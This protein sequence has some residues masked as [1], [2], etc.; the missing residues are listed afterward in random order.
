MITIN[1]LEELDKY[2]YQTI[3]KSKDK[4]FKVKLYKFTE[5]EE[6]ANV[7]FNIEIPFG[8]MDFQTPKTIKVKRRKK[9]NDLPDINF[10]EPLCYSFW[11]NN[12]VANKKFRVGRLYAN[13]VNLN[14]D[15]EIYSELLA[16]G[17]VKAKKLDYLIAKAF[18]KLK[19]IGL[20]NIMLDFAKNESL[21]P[22]FIQEA[23][24]VKN[25]YEAYK[26]YDYKE[27]FA[28]VSFLKEYL[29][30]GCAKNLAQI[31]YET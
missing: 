17:K 28:K 6:L 5:N 13:N 29:K 1:S 26:N 2:L 8:L 30:S 25:L 9:D 14:E 12:V 23:V 20:A 24:T 4:R 19:Y 7:V 3:P 11:L 18:V 22:E 15:S 27:F 10:A 16:K 31:L 21:H